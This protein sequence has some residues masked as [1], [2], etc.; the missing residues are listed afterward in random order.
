MEAMVK[1]ESKD[2]SQ[3]TSY[4]ELGMEQGTFYKGKGI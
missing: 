2:D 1:E 4:M 3:F